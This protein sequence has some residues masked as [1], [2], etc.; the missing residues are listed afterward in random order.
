MWESCGPDVH[1]QKDAGPHDFQGAVGAR[2]V[3]V[4]GVGI[5]TALSAARSDRRP[6]LSCLRVAGRGVLGMATGR[7]TEGDRVRPMDEAIEDRIGD[8]WIAEVRVPRVTRQLAGD[9][10]RAGAVAVLENF[11]QVLPLPVLEGRDREVVDF[12][13]LD[14]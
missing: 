7:T 11:E 4:H 13:L 5:S 1:R 6:S 14:V 10:R 9:H 3:S 12:V 8:R 2:S